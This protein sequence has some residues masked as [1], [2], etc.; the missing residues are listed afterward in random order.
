M[1]GVKYLRFDIVACFGLD[2]IIRHTTETIQ[3]TH[4][5]MTPSLLPGLQTQKNKDAKFDQM[6][7][8]FTKLIC[9]NTYDLRKAKWLPCQLHLL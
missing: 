3:T 6:K 1:L 4:F 8:T 9:P 5:C 2:E 7:A